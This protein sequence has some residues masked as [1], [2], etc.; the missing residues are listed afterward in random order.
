MNQPRPKTNQSIYIG[1]LWD[2]VRYGFDPL[3]PSTHE[4]PHKKHSI[5]S[6][7]YAQF[8]GFPQSTVFEKTET[9]TSM[10]NESFSQYFQGLNCENVGIVQ[11]SCYSVHEVYTETEASLRVDAALK[12]MKYDIA[13]QYI[14]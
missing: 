7:R 10:G 13:Y 2:L 8:L 6:D 11:N 9:E 12:G 3:L 4:N 14:Q 1:H 5:A